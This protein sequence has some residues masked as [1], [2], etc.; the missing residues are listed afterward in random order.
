MNLAQYVDSLRGGTS[1][2][3]AAAEIG[4][5]RGSL[6]SIVIGRTKNPSPYVL[7]KIA[8][9][10]GNNYVDQQK[11]YATLMKLA[12]YLDLMPRAVL[13]FTDLPSFPPSPVPQEIMEITNRISKLPKNQQQKII[14]GLT[15]F[16][17][18]VEQGN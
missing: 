12:G 3:D 17:E 13:D 8:E 18:L 16:V 1:Y 9:Y 11:I 4:V 10:Y 7:S 6:H 5:S 2:R 14:Q 15:T